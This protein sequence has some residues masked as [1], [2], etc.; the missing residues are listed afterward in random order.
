[1]RNHTWVIVDMPFGIKLV[2]CKWI[3]EKKFEGC[4]TKAVR[5]KARL[6]AK[7]FTQQEVDFTEV[8]SPV[9]KHNSIRILLAIVAQKDLELHQLDVRTTFLHGKLEEQIYMTL[10]EGL[11]EAGTSGKVFLL[12]KSLY[13][14]KYS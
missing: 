1:M 10:S 7:G 2:G 3:F 11:K 12:K 4:E 13:V 5:Y 9:V 14:L 6:V 8:F